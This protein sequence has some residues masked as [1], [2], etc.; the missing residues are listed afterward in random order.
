M[1]ASKRSEGKRDITFRFSNDF[2]INTGDVKDTFDQNRILFFHSVAYGQEMVSWNGY[3][4]QF[5]SRS[6][7][8]GFYDRHI[9]RYTFY[10]RVDMRKIF[11][12]KPESPHNALQLDCYGVG[13]ALTS[14]VVRHGCAS[15]KYSA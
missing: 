10:H 4:N 7:D 6:N 11:R 5:Q 3:M 2:M 14:T 12:V 15:L 9:I 1:Y 8:D 13:N